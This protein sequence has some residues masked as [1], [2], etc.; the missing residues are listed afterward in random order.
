[1]TGGSEW[2]RPLPHSLTNKQTVSTI[3]SIHR[4]WLCA[5][6]MFWLTTPSAVKIVKS[7]V[8]G[9]PVD[10]DLQGGQSIVRL[11]GLSYYPSHFHSY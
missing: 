5:C 8:I 2:P 6:R 3:S 10:V 9:V 1:M 7:T 4:C 11:M